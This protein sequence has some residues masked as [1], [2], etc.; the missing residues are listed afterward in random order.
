M[1]NIMMLSIGLGLVISLLLTEVLSLNAGGM[2]AV[3]YIALYLD[4]PGAVVMT[5]AASLVT[6][7]IVRFLSYRIF[8]YGR[9]Q[10]A[11]MLLVGFLVGAGFNAVCVFFTGQIPLA[12][13]QSAEVS[14]ENVQRLGVIGVVIPGL[15]AV[16][17]DRQ[18]IFPT[19]CGLLISSVI[20]RLIL[21]LL[22]PIQLQAIVWH[23]GMGLN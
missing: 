19:I 11:M 1:S 22:F 20:V 17:L 23:F 14:G 4:H 9:R 5:I 12:F 10:I 18:G 7:L 13:G 16:W 15:I 3:G 6:L 2:V 8:I 21:I